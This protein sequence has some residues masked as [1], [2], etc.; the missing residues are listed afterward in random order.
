M[1]LSKANGCVVEMLRF[2]VS[3]HAGSIRGQPTVRDA[4][5]RALLDWMNHYVLGIE[6]DIDT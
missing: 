2:P 4:Q 3:A 6:P 5:N 1:W